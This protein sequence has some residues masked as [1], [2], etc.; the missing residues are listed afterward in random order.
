M[1]ENVGQYIYHNFHTEIRGHSLYD[2]C[3]Y[4]S[5]H[6]FS[7]LFYGFPYCLFQADVFPGDKA[8]FSETLLNLSRFTPKLMILQ[9]NIHFIFIQKTISTEYCKI[10]K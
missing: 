4:C 9:W 3:K 2:M 8:F 1:G 6:R 7:Y 10:V 5:F